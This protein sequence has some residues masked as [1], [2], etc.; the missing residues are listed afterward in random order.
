MKV[1]RVRWIDEYVEGGESAVLVG[2]QVFVLSELATA[3]LAAVGGR[4]VE[5]EEI[6]ALLGELFGPPPEGADLLAATTDAVRE[7]DAQGLVTYSV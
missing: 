1:R 7:L 6:A 2:D 3:V 5:V 4:T